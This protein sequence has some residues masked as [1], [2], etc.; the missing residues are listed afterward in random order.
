MVQV[1][2]EKEIRQENRIFGRFTGRQVVCF[3]IVAAVEIA[4]YLIV[5]PEVDAIIFA[6]I[7]L[8]I[9]AW[10]FGFHKKCGISMEYFWGKKIKAFILQN[11]SRKYRT[12]NRYVATLNRSYSADRSADMADKRTKKELH[13]QQKASAKAK[14]STKLKSYA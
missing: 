4:F 9:G 11:T 7:L 1:E 3:G 13:R 12:K 2:I 5:H 10:Y 14:K 6:G 8:G